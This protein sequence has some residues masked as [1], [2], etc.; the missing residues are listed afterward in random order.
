MTHP[1]TAIKEA[2]YLAKKKDGVT[3]RKIAKEIGC[4]PANLYELIAR[5]GTESEFYPRLGDWLIGAGYLMR[6]QPGTA[7][8]LTARLVAKDQE[9]ERA[10][11]LLAKLTV[12][13]AT[14]I[15]EIDAA[16]KPKAK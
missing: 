9:I 15:Q 11:E 8:I 5:E 1:W 12:E 4:S 13:K 10:R 6:S 3:V 2:L 16:L 14:I 7:S